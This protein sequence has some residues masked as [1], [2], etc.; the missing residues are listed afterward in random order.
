MSDGVKRYGGASETQFARAEAISQIVAA[1]SALM[2]KRS[3]RVDLNNLQDVREAA[4]EYI[5]TCANYGILPT[6]EGFSAVL[7]HSRR[8]VYKYLANHPDSETTAFIDSLRTSWAAARI[9]AADRG[10]ASESVSIFVLL[11]SNLDFTNE[12]KIA[13]E[14][15]R[16]PFEV[17][18]DEVESVRKKYLDTLP[19]LESE[20][21]TVL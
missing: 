3:V 1:Q 20:K 13:I 12:H 21:G 18:T 17:S 5:E 7:G 14:P 15:A 6:V 8:N 4:G 11:N 2:T 19:E 9:A 16:T 10:A